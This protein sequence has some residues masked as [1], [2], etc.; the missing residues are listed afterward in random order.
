MK[1]IITLIDITMIIWITLKL[2]HFND[3]VSTHW[4]RK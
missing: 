2:R 4:Y 3:R 1:D